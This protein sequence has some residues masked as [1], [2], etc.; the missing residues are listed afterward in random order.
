MTSEDVIIIFLQLNENGIKF[1]N[2]Y[3]HK[4]MLA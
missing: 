4:K 2:K 1:N 3:I